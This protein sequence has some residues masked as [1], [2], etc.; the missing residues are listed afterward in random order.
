MLDVLLKGEFSVEYD[1]E[2]LD[3]FSRL[4]RRIS[5]LYD[6]KQTVFTKI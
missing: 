6:S 2:V 3:C 5:D 1:A 4:D